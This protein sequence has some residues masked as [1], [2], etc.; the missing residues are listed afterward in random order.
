[1]ARKIKP[2]D[3]DALEGIIAMM[4]SAGRS[5]ILIPISVVEAMIEIAR[6]VAK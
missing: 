2:A 5:K 3:L 4:R 6:R 1:M